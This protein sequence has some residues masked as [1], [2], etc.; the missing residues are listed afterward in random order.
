[1]SPDGQF[2]SYVAPVHGV[3]N[4]WVRSATGGEDRPVTNSTERDIWLYRWTYAVGKLL[5]RHD[6][7]GEEDWILWIADAFS[8]QCTRVSPLREKGA[9]GSQARILALSPDCPSKAVIGLNA[10]DPR[11]HDAYLLDLDTGGLTL[12]A[13]APDDILFLYWPSVYGGWLVDHSLAIRGYLAARPGGGSALMLRDS[14]GSYKQALAWGPEDALWSG[15]AQFARD[16][17]RLYLIDSSG[18]DTAAL[19]EL[20][21][22]TGGRRELAADPAHDTYHVS[23][24]LRTGRPDCVAIERE[25]FD[26]VAI[27]DAVAPDLQFL[28]TNATG[29]FTLCGRSQDDRTWLVETYADVSPPAMSLYHRP[30]KRLEPLF[31]VNEAL[32]GCEFAA[33]KPVSFAARDGLAL[34]GYLTLPRHGQPPFPLVLRAHGGPWDRVRW[35]FDGDDQWLADR[36]YAS[37]QVN[38]RG[39]IGYGKSFVQAGNR[40]W[41]GK[42][43]DDLDDAVAWAIR[44]G[45][46]DAQRIAIMGISYGGYAVLSS[47]TFS[48]DIYR[49]GL[50]LMPLADLVSHLAT[51][52]PYMENRRGRD[53]VLIGRLPRYMDGSRKGQPKDEADWTQEDRADIEFLRSR[54]PI[55]FTDRVRSPLLIVHGA[56]DARIC[57]EES[58]R[59]AAALQARHIPVEY[60][61]YPEAG[62]YFT[63][64]SDALDFY[65]RAER[66]LAEHLGSRQCD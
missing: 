21:T 4:V 32:S 23:F 47:L 24:D 41:G 45:V 37:L 56:N 5:F 39:S 3:D 13:E 16:N 34:H 35:R 33:T 44:Q 7:A 63:K 64:Q 22:A 51:C 66:F 59:F 58:A 19:V 36:G 2:I 15:P 43:Q 53:D 30:D 10:R 42:M 26:W 25:R 55:N 12:L 49:A 48:P 60:V 18:R 40:E 1:L 50:A 38:F 46:A 11:L 54:S 9:A 28:Q 31:V 62:H 61:V 14:A 57:C 8:G 20:D 17:R 6:K 27:D 52:P 29:A 65:R